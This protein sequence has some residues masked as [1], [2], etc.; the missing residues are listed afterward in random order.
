V[1]LFGS[2]AYNMGRNGKN[3][4]ARIHSRRVTEMDPT[5]IRVISGVIFV[6]IVFVIF[7]RRKRMATQRKRVP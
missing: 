2:V 3:A 4:S 1:L 5:T 7:A 6:A